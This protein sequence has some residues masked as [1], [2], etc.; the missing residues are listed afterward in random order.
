MCLAHI[1]SYSPPDSLKLD[2]YSNLRDIV[3]LELTYKFMSFF[4][5]GCGRFLI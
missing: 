4:Y 2:Y 3:S 1:I 5:Y